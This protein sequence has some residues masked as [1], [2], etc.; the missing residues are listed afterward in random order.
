M[1]KLIHKHTHKYIALLLA[2]CLALAALTYI[3]T[4]Q[5]A[6]GASPLP[7]SVQPA[8][9]FAI[10]S[11][12][13]RAAWVTQGTLKGAKYGYAVA[14][15]GDVNGDG[16]DDVLVGAP[17]HSQLAEKDG[18]AYLFYGSD[19]GLSA[20]A[21]WVTGSGYKGSQFGQS[22]DSAGDVN[23]DGYDDVIVGAYRYK[24]GDLDTE[25][26][27][28]F[29][30]YGSADGL[31]KTPG[32]QVESDQTGAQLGYA[33]AG[34]GDLN[35]DGYAD[36]AVGAR[37]FTDNEE[38]QGGVYV[39]YGT[40]SG[41]E[42]TYDRLFSGDQMGAY[43]GSALGAA[44]DLNG[45][46]YDDLVVGAPGLDYQELDAGAAYVFHGSQD[47]LGMTWDWR[48]ISDQ[49]EAGF[50]V[51]VSTAGD[52]DGDGYDDVIIGAPGYAYEP[53]ALGS[54][55]VYHG[56]KNGLPEQ[57]SWRADSGQ[58][59]AWFGMAAG[60]AGDVNLDGYDDVIVGAYKYNADQPDEGSTFVY[61]GT[62]TGLRSYYGWWTAGDKADAWFGY[63]V[64][65]AGDVNGDGSADVLVGAPNYRVDRDLMGRAYLYMGEAGDEPPPAPTPT[66]PPEPDG[67]SLYLPV[68]LWENP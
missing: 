41:P 20:T 54:V 18:A 12:S 33:V 30:Y 10:T 65:T 48:A 43:F 52:V 35:G 8:S 49:P 7:G 22:L 46:G 45:D 21:G 3:D 9:S 42:T 55:F 39:Y 37:Y 50:G 19:D 47:G 28:A 64:A 32:W 26:G 13:D 58:S 40:K 25:E 1:A 4:S 14:S 56:S 53:A 31:S 62:P 2:S 66:E 44:G 6:A 67:A 36:L 51:A 57:A 17:L 11:L 61:F 68:L 60:T 59:T 27:A 15:A 38:K 23:G 5:A 24:N 29:L 63:A 34:A 16:Y